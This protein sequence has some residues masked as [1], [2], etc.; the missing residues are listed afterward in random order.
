MRFREQR[1]NDVAPGIEIG[2]D[3][4]ELAETRLPEVLRQDLPSSVVRGSRP[5]AAPAAPRRES[6]PR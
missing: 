3:E 4:Y 6:D 2:G 5:M 1:R